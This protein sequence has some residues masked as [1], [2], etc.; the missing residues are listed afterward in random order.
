MI[1]M[2]P[3]IL[4]WLRGAK[5]VKLRH[6][7]RKIKAKLDAKRVTKVDRAMKKIT[8]IKDGRFGKYK[9]IQETAEK[10]LTAV[11][12]VY[13]EFLKASSAAGGDD[14]KLADLMMP[15]MDA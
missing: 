12:P 11:K 1:F 10:A 15:H 9:E 2:K 7:A 5:L 8:A 13:D 14:K 6:Y 4:A 3:G